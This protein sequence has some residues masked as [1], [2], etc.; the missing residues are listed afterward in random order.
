MSRQELSRVNL[1][2]AFYD[3]A[4]PHRRSTPLAKPNGAGVNGPGGARVISAV[5]PSAV[6]ASQKHNQKPSI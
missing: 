5:T 1:M 3:T 4:T 2:S 6:I